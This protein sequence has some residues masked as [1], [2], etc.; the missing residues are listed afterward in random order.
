MNK[1]QAYDAK[2]DPLMT[3]IIAICREHGIAMFASFA[4]PTP[5]DEG[6]F[7]TTHLA[8]GAGEIL[9]EFADC[10]AII[11]PKARGVAMVTTQHADGTKTITAILG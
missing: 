8:D 11:R 1:D 7:C 6:L 3:Q 5:E 9:E 4:L 2:I 10:F